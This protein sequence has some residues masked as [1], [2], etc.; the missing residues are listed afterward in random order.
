METPAIT[1]GFVVD[2]ACAA[3]P[4]STTDADLPD[5]R[6]ALGLVHPDADR[7]SAS[8][9]ELPDRLRRVPG[10]DLLDLL[11]AVAGVH[12]PDLR[13]PSMK[14]TLRSHADPLAICAAVAAAWRILREWPTAFQRLAS[15]R[16]AT[17]P[18]NGNVTEARSDPWI[19]PVPG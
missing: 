8:A 12:S 15:E 1:N 6:T 3:A 19:Q 14:Q 11:V 5:L 13:C 16:I 2:D 4:F 17:R 10:G 18:G 7:R 9:D